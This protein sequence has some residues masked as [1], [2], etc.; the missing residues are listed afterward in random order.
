[1]NKLAVII[2]VY[3]KDE[4]ELLKK[5]VDSILAQSFREFDLIIVADGP[6]SSEIDHYLGL[7]DSKCFAIIRYPHN[8]GL[9]ATLNKAISFC[10]DK[11]HTYIA[12]MDADDISHERRLE[13]QFRYLERSP[14]IG[15]VGV[16][17]N[18]ID[19]KGK[20]IGIKTVAPKINYNI[21][22][23]VSDV[24]HPSVVFR[25]SF[26]EKVGFY[27]SSLYQSQDYD[28]WF[29]AVE[30]NIRI[31]NIQKKLYYL[32]YDD[33][34]IRRRKKAQR[35]VLKIKIRYLRFVDF[36]YLFSHIL[37]IVLPECIVRSILYRKIQTGETKYY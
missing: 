8:E 20:V 31:H 9:P 12:R 26:F 33:R 16:E 25:T 6:V 14:D 10:M 22:K 30:K 11:G 5:S 28:L 32:R 21:L 29:R 15:A 18:I 1:M 34:L 35:Y 2:P 27:D 17:A 7:I 24:I 37:I 23:K 13:E 19:S 4:P 36:F 3:L